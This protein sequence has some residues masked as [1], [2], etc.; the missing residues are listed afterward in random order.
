GKDTFLAIQYLGTDRLPALF[1]MKARFDSVAARGKFLPGDLSAEIMEA[2]SGLCPGH[3]PKRLKDYRDKFEHHL[4][5]KMSGS[6][7]K[8][9]RTYLASAFPSDQ[10]AFFECSPAEGEKAESTRAF[11]ANRAGSRSVATAHCLDKIG[12]PEVMPFRES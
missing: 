11:I 5:L 12:R 8:E 4:M 9:A 2:V 10:G 6:G 1:A 3:L 7:I